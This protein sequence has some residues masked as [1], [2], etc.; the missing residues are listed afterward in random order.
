MTLH[1][2]G[3]RWARLLRSLGLFFTLSLGAQAQTTSPL[4]SQIGIAPENNQGNTPLFIRERVF[5]GKLFQP[6]QT[7]GTRASNAITVRA[8]PNTTAGTQAFTLG[9][10]AQADPH[11]LRVL[12]NGHDVSAHFQGAA[13]GGSACAATL[14][15][16]DGLNAA[17][18]VLSATVRTSSGSMASGRLRSVSLLVTPTRTPSA[19]TA[20]AATRAIVKAGSSAAAS[21]CDPINM[22]PAWLPPSVRFDTLTQGGWKPGPNAWISVNGVSYPSTGGT[23]DAPPYAV[24]VFNRQTLA[25]TDFE[26]FG[27]AAAFTSYLQ[28]KTSND[29]VVGGTTNIPSNPVTS[30][31]D[32][33]S[34]GGTNFSQVLTA[35]PQSY[36]VIGAGQQSP[37]TAYESTVSTAAFATGSLQED[38]NG[39]YSFQSSDVIEYAIQPQDSAEYQNPTIS[40]NVPPNQSVAGEKRIIFEANAPAGS[41]GLWLLVLNRATPMPPYYNLSSGCQDNNPPGQPI[42]VMTGCGTFY[43]VN[44]GNAG[45]N[46]VAWH[47]LA[48]ALGA[49]T[50]DQLVLLQSIGSVG[51]SDL[52]TT[53]QSNQAYSGFLAFAGALERFGGTPILVAGPTF[54]SADSY[55]FVGF[56]R[57][58]AVAPPP[59]AAA[60]TPG[61]DP[62]TA[63]LD[64]RTNALTGG[65]AEISTALP[66]QSGVLHGTLQR[67]ADNLYRP[68]QVS[69]EP[70]QMFNDKG[71]LDDSDFVMSVASYQQSVDWPSNSATTLLPGADSIAG[72]KAAFRFL[73]HWLLSGY[74]VKGLQG[75]HQDDL[76]YFFTGSINTSLNYHVMDPANLNFP[77]Q[78]T[79]DT[80]GCTS[81]DGAT[82]TFTATGD[83]ASSSF[84]RDDFNAVRGQLSQEV[85][86]LTNTLQFLV[87]GST[88]LKD[89]VGGGS[90]NVGLALNAAASTVLGSG[91]TNLNQADIS[92]KQVSISWQAILGVIGGAV[93]I[94]ADAEGF[95][96]ITEAYQLA[97]QATKNSLK[98]AT[99]AANTLAG[100]LGAVGS[101]GSIV[102]TTPASAMPQPFAKL[103]TTIGELATKNLQSPLLL[104][105]DTTVDTIASDWGRLS[106]IG[107][108]V[109]NTN[110]TTFYS[111]NQS[112]QLMAVNGLTSAATS[113]FYFALLPQIYK[114]HYWTGV[115]AAGVTPGVFQPSMGYY[116][117]HN[118]GPTCNAFYLSPSSNTAAGQ[119]LGALTNQGTSFPSF[120]G[121]PRPFSQDI[122]STDFWLADGTVT[123]PKAAGTTIQVIDSDLATNL[124]SRSQ[125]GIPAAQFFSLNGPLANVA[126]DASVDN[127]AGWSN[128]D[129]CDASDPSYGSANPGSAS[130]TSS[131]TD[132]AGRLITATAWISPMSSMLG[133]DA[134][135]TA[136]VMA[137]TKAAISG[138]IY[139]TVDGNVVGSKAVAADGTSS[140]A[141]AGLTI[142]KHA[143]QADYAPG[144]GYAASSASPS[145][146]VVYSE[147]PDLTLSL[148]NTSMTVS[149]NAS[150]TPVSLQ[151]SS[152]AGLSGNVALSCT[153]LPAGLVCSFNS[154]SLKLDPASSVNASVSIG[155]S[156]TTQ[157]ALSLLLLPVLGLAW[158]SKGR[159]TL[160]RGV[161]IVVASGIAAAT[162]NGCSSGSN[163]PTTTQETGSKTVLVTATVGSLSRSVPVTITIH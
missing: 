102:T 99:S 117:D 4:T 32:T 104:S 132:S 162:L 133:G 149:Y 10:P 101:G 127:V 114:L 63:L 62:P 145:T 45:D 160:L 35:M 42:R 140:F 75:P 31:L 22:C 103:T 16:E 144:T 146:F 152:V 59:P 11:S 143:V 29:L 111:P 142:G 90:A 23:T 108:R 6:E 50:S 43:P 88:N 82:C 26:W 85:V 134:V 112:S 79:W 110:D 33:S 56:S 115:A 18:N 13:C 107:P 24:L 14:S 77:G 27:S 128:G 36:M 37:G 15:A 163:T 52:R 138:L 39:N 58:I 64:N 67:G 61:F 9:L 94:A 38:V 97:S 123:K 73:S 113:N 129:V 158:R 125:L 17:K 80:F 106:S 51:T 47:A 96:E 120:G 122:G 92:K 40:L 1:K 21:V 46:D 89:I 93:S 98:A 159:L 156:T 66:D 55:A 20:S 71:Y 70:Q 60:G 48:G 3:I 19:M 81:S 76:H 155:P 83:S 135:L 100:T 30:D 154:K 151:I 116:Q 130:P 150:S 119:K 8:E 12:L 126:F 86:Y 34:I 57:G 131:G 91:M 49:V 65:A 5:A 137:G 25:L 84:T 74:Y 41:N 44:A 136:Q 7:T 28:G 121:S 54:S 124:F 139:F 105:F 72:Q 141:V 118:S 69:A 157:V 153:G 53:V 2:T 68:F 147:S 87:T 109:T 148:A 161:L 95:G 78:G